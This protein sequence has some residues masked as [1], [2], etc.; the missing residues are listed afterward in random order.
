MLE[1]FILFIFEASSP[2]CTASRLMRGLKFSGFH[3]N[4]LVVIFQAALLD[5]SSV[6]ILQYWIG[7]VSVAHVPRICA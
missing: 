2:S 7:V 4:L 1:H 5:I 3:G 6:E